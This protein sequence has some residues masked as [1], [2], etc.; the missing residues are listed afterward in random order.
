MPLNVKGDE[1]E[2][3][4]VKWALGKD[5]SLDQLMGFQIVLLAFITFCPREIFRLHEQI[6]VSS[7]RILIK[8]MQNHIIIAECEDYFL[9]VFQ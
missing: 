3:R 5:P 6:L 4:M 2:K 7:F 1:G 8:E 9:Y